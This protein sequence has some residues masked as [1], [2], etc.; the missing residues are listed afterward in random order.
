MSVLVAREK[1]RVLE[2][3]VRFASIEANE[4]LKSH[5]DGRESLIAKLSSRSY[6][7]DQPSEWSGICIA[8]SF[9]C[10]KAPA[11]FAAAA[12]LF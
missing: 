3:K 11:D 8:N 6:P 2:K 4:W 1:S 12:S 7:H 9:I 5:S 10:S